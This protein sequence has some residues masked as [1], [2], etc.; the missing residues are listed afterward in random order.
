[1]KDGVFHS[2]EGYYYVLK[3]KKSLAKNRDGTAIAKEYVKKFVE[4]NPKYKTLLSGKSWHQI[5]SIMG[6]KING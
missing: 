1:M 3:G 5:F 6:I 4:Q 2:K